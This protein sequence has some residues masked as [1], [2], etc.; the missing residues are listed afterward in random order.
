MNVRH[1]RKALAKVYS[2]ALSARRL[3]G[4]QRCRAFGDTQ[5]GKRGTIEKIFVVNLDREQNRYSRVLSELSRVLDAS[6]SP[7]TNRVT[8]V[9]A[10]DATGQ[11]NSSFKGFVEPTYTLR[12]QLF[13]DPYP[14]VLPEHLN[15]DE[16][17]DMSAQEI[18]VA[19]SHIGVWQRIAS[20]ND[21]YALV[22]EDDVWFH[23]RFAQL[24]DKAWLELVDAS[25]SSLFDL[26]Y[27]S[28]REVE[29]GAEKVWV[30][31]NVFTPIRGLWYLS[32]YVLSIQGAQKLLASLPVRGPVDL[33]INHQFYRLK[34]YGTAQSVVKQR[35]D[36]SSSNCYS[37]LP[38]LSRAGILNTEK[39]GL[40]AA[41]PSLGPIFA[42][43]SSESGLS[44]LA[45]ALSML[46]Y[47]CCSDVDRLP[48]REMQRLLNKDS[49]RVFSAYVNV[50]SL[51]TQ[52][53]AL[54]HIYPD[55]R[56]ILIQRD[57]DKVLKGPVSATVESRGRLIGGKLRAEEGQDRQLEPWADRALVLDSS[58]SN[59]WKAL[60]EF[61][62]C[63]PPAAAYPSPSD[64]GQ[65]VLSASADDGPA[66]DKSL[67]PMQFD[68][69]PWIAPRFQEWNG[70][71][72]IEGAMTL[73]EKPRSVE[74]VDKFG[75][76]DG[77][78]WY[79]RNDTFPGN[80][81]LFKPANFSSP[82]SGSAHLQLRRENC[83]VR[84]YSSA[85]LS[86]RMDFLHGRFE[87]VLKPSP[88]PGVVTG[89][90][91]H[92]DSP[93][94]EIDIEFVGKRPR[95]MLT[96][97]YYNPGSEGARYD[98]GYRGSPI[99]VDLGFD[100]SVAFHTY[101]IEWTASSLRW[102]VDGRLV[103]RRA[104]WDPTPIPQ[105]PMRF[106]LNLWP[107][108]SS[109]LAGRLRDRDLPAACFVQAI[110]L[111]AGSAGALTT[112]NREG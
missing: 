70:M 30:S 23:P 11:H 56:L 72:S 78:L 75:G 42:I 12:D 100:A 108:R 107:S 34:V 76:L 40:F 101:A 81:A 21:E 111:D 8:R 3:L 60:C 95:Q 41:R 102:Y 68:E 58:A 1:L 26:M 77:N 98:Y 7:L 82:D 28:Y 50:A 25:S 94:Q 106:H 91:L 65:R 39:P 35:R 87:A 16:Q 83:G 24:V 4:P 13:V 20:G 99:L 9:A 93:R 27:V 90:F 48:D 61:L 37:I 66:K 97:V 110:N 92:R 31:P 89:M 109:E 59:A 74:I 19:S 96:N 43:G 54:A 86:S 18:A 17:I 6:E 47:R 88:V 80:L 36:E 5:N 62:R 22:L 112:F 63:V 57:L 29:H 14:A 105:L 33:W 85:A 55:G 49:R 2:V 53:S 38:V 64:R 32:G 45:M 15:L 104:N 69:S 103:H 84:S 71:P 46:G 52:L 67:Q 79:L 44:A 73:H 10:V 51:D